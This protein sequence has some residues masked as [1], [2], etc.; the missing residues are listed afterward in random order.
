MFTTISN[1]FFQTSTIKYLAAKILFGVT[2]LGFT[3]T[4]L[5]QDLGSQCITDTLCEQQNLPLWEVGVAGVGVYAPDYPGADEHSSNQLV[6]PYFVYRGEV[7]RAGDG[8]ILRALAFE[9]DTFELDLSVDASFRAD[10]DDNETRQGMDDLDFLFG[11]GPQLVVNLLKD[12]DKE[13]NLSLRFQVR[14]VF[15]TDFSYID[16]QGY[17]VETQLRYEQ[18]NFIFPKLRFVGSIGPIWASEKLMDYFYQVTPVDV[19]AERNQYDASGGYL[20]TELNLALALPIMKDKGR[21]FVGARANLHNGS[22]NE[23]SPLFKDDINYSFALGFSY[24]LFESEF[25][26]R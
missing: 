8:G 7:I 17:A 26:A 15:S 16:Q 3:S 18:N 2:S 21:V 23:D 4:A 25:K 24:K 9:D 20:G 5:A 11:I 22:A 6:V 1:K 12:E 19:N 10:S 14:S 13:H